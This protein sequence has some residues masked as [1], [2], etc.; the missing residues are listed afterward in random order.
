MESVEIRFPLNVFI[1]IIQI[2]NKM[3]IKDRN[4]YFFF[5]R[6]YF[7]INAI[8]QLILGGDDL[9]LENFWKTSL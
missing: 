8:L 3:F 5:K 7:N 6:S 4:S 9:Q 2:K 1:I